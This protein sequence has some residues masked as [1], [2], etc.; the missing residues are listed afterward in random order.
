MYATLAGSFK[1]N[2]VYLNLANV[3]GLPITPVKMA[4]YQGHWVWNSTGNSS[5]PT[6]T[7]SYT[8]FV[9]VT[10]TN[11]AA[12]YGTVG[13]P[14]ISNAGGIV[15]SITAVPSS[16]FVPLH[17]SFAASVSGANGT[18]SYSW[19]FGDLKGNTST[20]ATPKD[21]YNTT[22]TYLVALTVHDSIGNQGSATQIITV[23]VPF[24]ASGQASA[25]VG[26]CQWWYTN[27]P[28]NVYWQVWNNGSQSISISGHEYLNDTTAGTQVQSWSVSTSVGAHSTTGLT[29]VANGLQVT[30][31]DTFVVTLRLTATVN[32]QF[33]GIITSTFSVTV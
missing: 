10:G 31:G 26:N 20:S 1:T 12:I 22:G 19:S 4:F 11:G 23:S 28:I 5:G 9:N 18:I 24:S 27:C 30:N 13:I 32:G 29:Q 21:W 17:V 25:T 15:V 16:G 3:P 33:A 6:L 7:G 2:S 8:G 14:V